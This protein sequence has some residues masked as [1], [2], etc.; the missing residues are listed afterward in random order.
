MTTIHDTLMPAWEAGMEAIADEPELIDDIE[1]VIDLLE[2]HDYTIEDLFG[3]WFTDRGGNLRVRS[4]HTANKAPEG[5]D[6][7]VAS[8]FSMFKWHR[9]GGSIDSLMIAS[10]ALGR[11]LYGQVETLTTLL[12]QIV[13]GR[14]PAARRWEH[15]LYGR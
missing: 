14:S 13:Y 11:T 2:E 8:G 5:L 3:H 15:A 7:L 9:S 10:F 12:N 4:R 1:A 6:D